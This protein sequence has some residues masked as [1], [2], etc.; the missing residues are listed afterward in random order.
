MRG[1]LVFAFRRGAARA[2]LGVALLGGVWTGLERAYPWA[3]IRGPHILPPG[4]PAHALATNPW[5]A[6]LA[7]AGIGFGVVAAVLVW[8]RRPVG[9]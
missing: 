2:L 8:R 3:Q 4:V 7:V 6:V 1:V 9:R 5:D